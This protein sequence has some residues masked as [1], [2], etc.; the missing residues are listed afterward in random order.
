MCAAADSGARAHP[1]ARMKPLHSYLLAAA[2]CS[3][4]SSCTPDE[5][6]PQQF[7][8]DV[9]SIQVV[10]EKFA[11][12]SGSI[13]STAEGLEA[14]VER[15]SEW[16]PERGWMKL[17]ESIPTDAWGRE[18]RYQSGSDVEASWFEIRSVGA[19]GVLSDDDQVRRL[20]IT[21]P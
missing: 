1:W 21:A 11:A 10:V 9:S 4:G 3:L 2:L 18:Y 7:E 19:D 20:T 13:P 12:V 5:A 6:Y 15:P 8:R 17:I 14:C 16:A